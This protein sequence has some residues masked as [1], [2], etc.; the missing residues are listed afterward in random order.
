[1]LPELKQT[2]PKLMMKKKKM[3]AYANAHTAMLENMFVFVCICCYKEQTVRF[4][5][6]DSCEYGYPERNSGDKQQ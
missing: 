4:L 3:S 1:V 2:G 6:F 5:P